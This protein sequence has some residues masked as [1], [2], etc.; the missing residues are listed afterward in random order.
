M[1]YLKYLKPEF[2]VRYIG[3]WPPYLL[4]GI[5]VDSIDSDFLKIDVKM[6]QRFYNT[7]YVGTHFGGS[8]YSMCDPFY[9]FILIKHLGQNH[10]VW[11]KSAKIEFIKPGKK[12]V[13]ASFYIPLKKI[14]RIERLA[15]ENYKVEPEFETQVFDEEGDVVAR[16]YKRLYVRRKDVKKVSS[17]KNNLL[18]DR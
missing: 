16:V 9:M 14:Q 4:A 2:V 1:K 17:E 12:I 8:L 7:N 10:I 5:S 15:L 11:D 18:N 13:R 3:L 6:R